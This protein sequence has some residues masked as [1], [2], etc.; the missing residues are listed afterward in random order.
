MN[1][2]ISIPD[3]QVRRLAETTF[4]RNVVVVAGAGTGKT[5]LL[6]NRLVHL[7]VREPNPADITRIVALTFTNKAAT[8]MK[9]RLRAR[10]KA[11]LS[12]EPLDCARGPE[13]LDPEALD[14]PVEGQQRATTDP[15]AVRVENLRERYGLSSDEIDKRARAALHDLEKA[16]IG[17]L[18]SF[19]AHLLRLYPLESGVDPAFETDDDG[20][21]FE[22][23]FATQWEL[24]LDSELGT[25]GSD[26]ARWRRLLDD[27]GL[28][29]IREVAYALR[30][31]L[32]PI[33]ELNRQAGAD[34][35][36]PALRDWFATFD[37]ESWD[38]QMEA[39]A[40]EG[41]LER[42]SEGALRD[43]LDA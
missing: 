2:P 30:S 25:N 37:A 23:H 15:G 16:Q 26:H 19:A 31:E 8:E 41:K 9:V 36:A 13:S 42:L 35:L 39:D 3:A 43:H 33:E 12:P 17:T 21:R 20:L 7:V 6:V 24:W 34:A 1:E 29:Q 11:L 14:G 5:T 4:D 40:R 28:E 27:V 18:H 10:L 22:E 38:R 32:I